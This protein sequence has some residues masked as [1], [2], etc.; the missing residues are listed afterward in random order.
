MARTAELSRSN[1]ALELEIAERRRAQE[2]S[3]ALLSENRSL[4][5][6]SLALQESER[7]HLARE[8]HD[9]LGQC[10]TAIQADAEII[11]DRAGACDSRLIASATAIQEVSSRIY[12][13]VHSMMHRLRPAMLDDL[14]LEE[15]LRGEVDAWQ[16]RHPGIDCNLTIGKDL[17]DLGEQLNIAVYRIVQE[18]LTNIAKH[19]AAHHVSIRLH[20]AG[21]GYAASGGGDSATDHIRL[22]VQDDGRGFEPHVR[23]AGLGLVGM[24]ER[25]E[26]LAGSFAVVSTSGAGTTVTVDLPLT[27]SETGAS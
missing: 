18:C 10:I 17:G 9:E 21:P 19:A 22:V 26:G 24:R 16:S 8:L 5:R 13:V 1:Q 15:T 7:R 20:R 25:V 3:S 12:E 4:I 27:L 2:A 23:G 14:G 6:N 11:R